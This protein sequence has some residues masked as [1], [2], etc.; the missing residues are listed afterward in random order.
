MMSLF[1]TKIKTI[2]ILLT[3]V[4][5]P[6]IYAQKTD[7]TLPQTIIFKV[8]EQFRANCS[9][10]SVTITGFH[11]LSTQ[12]GIDKLEKIFPTKEKEKVAGNVDLSLI[13]ELHY[14]NSIPIEEVIFQLKN[15]KIA[16][17]VEPYYLPKLCYTP[18]DTLL[19][20]QYYLNLIN[21]NYNF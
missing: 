1:Y 13:Y 16:E 6:K 10:T 19:S 18:N 21:K 2:F 5:I 14:T 8:K 20:S 12:I 4:W 11:Q 15:L 3:I 9:K 17:Y 7:E